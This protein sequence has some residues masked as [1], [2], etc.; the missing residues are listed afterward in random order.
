[1]AKK[2]CEI[3]QDLLPLYKDEICGK[4]TKAFVE[5][6]L[7]ECEEC[8]AKL[9]QINNE[10]IVSV[11][12]EDAG[13][14]FRKYF[15]KKK[16]NKIILSVIFLLVL[17]IMAVGI[18]AY[19]EKINE[20]SEFYNQRSKVGS[21]ASV[22]AKNDFNDL[23]YNYAVESVERDINTAVD[24]ICENI[25]DSKDK[26]YDQLMQYFCTYLRSFT[27]I[28]VDRENMMSIYDLYSDNVIVKLAEEA[29]SYYIMS[30]TDG[31][32]AEENKQK[33]IN[34]IDEVKSNQTPEVEE[35]VNILILEGTKVR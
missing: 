9:G 2:I 33:L 14:M 16:R 15:R 11:I 3:I 5:E 31:S 28:N 35:F 25:N 32:K 6:H 12:K 13:E 23:S 27:L 34:L 22:Q 18:L 7:N 26:D 1:M 8:K 30:Q 17:I 21:L 29:N 24:Y 4:E 20:V 10:E 19:R